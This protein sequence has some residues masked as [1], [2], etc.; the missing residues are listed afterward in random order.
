M[1]LIP[2]PELWEDVSRVRLRP[3]FK[4]YSWC[5]STCESAAHCCANCPPQ[6]YNGDADP[7]VPI[8]TVGRDPCALDAP[9]IGVVCVVV[10]VCT[11]EYVC[12][13]CV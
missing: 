7:Y 13:V 10:R 11:K 2:H 3:R 9:R 1:Y 12:V 6:L 4:S 8:C 5:P